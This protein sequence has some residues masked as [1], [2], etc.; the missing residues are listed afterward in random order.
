MYEN[1][2]PL[3]RRYIFILFKNPREKCMFLICVTFLMHK[4]NMDIIIYQKQ[5]YRNRDIWYIV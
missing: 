1:S 2:F 3:V 4:S 5:I